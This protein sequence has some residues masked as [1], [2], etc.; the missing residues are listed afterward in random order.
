VLNGDSLTLNCI[1]KWIFIKMTKEISRITMEWN[2]CCSKFEV[3]Q[4]HH[5][6]IS[7]RWDLK[8][9]SI[10][11]KTARPL[12]R[13]QHNFFLIQNVSNTSKSK[14]YK[15]KSVCVCVCVP[16]NRRSAY[17]YVHLLWQTN[18]MEQN[19]SWEFDSSSCGQ[20]IY[21]ILWNRRFISVFTIARHWT[22]SWA[23]W[24]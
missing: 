7:E 6:G 23:R 8:V 15:Y 22:L 5:V 14:Q 2:Y 11:C 1:C 10:I 24:I 16:I 13:M 20:D 21:R 3:S 17:E 18:V 4:C 12:Y 9:N 19:P